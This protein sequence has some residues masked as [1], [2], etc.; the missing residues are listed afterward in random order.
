MWL[1]SEF[2]SRKALNKTAHSFR[3]FIVPTC[4]SVWLWCC[5]VLFWPYSENC[6]HIWGLKSTHYF[7]TTTTLLSLTT[8]LTDTYGHFTKPI[9]NCRS[10]YPRGLRRRSSSAPL[11]SFWVR[12]PPESWMSLYSECCV[13]SDRGLC[14]ELI[15]RPEKSYRLWCVVLCDQETSIMRRPWPT[16]GLSHQK[17]TTNK[18]L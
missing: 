17:Q 4:T 13:L 16:G 6:M 7:S 11:L 10:N 5:I 3:K 9:C 14:D 15:T 18:L 8:M 1:K 12:I 2:A